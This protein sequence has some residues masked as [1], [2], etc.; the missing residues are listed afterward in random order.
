MVIGVMEI[1]LWLSEAHSLKDKRQVV[2]S[3]KDKIRDRFN[4]AV[5]EVADQDLWQKA[6]LAVCTVGSD[7]RVVNARLDQVVNFV[8]RLQVA[9]DLDFRLEMINL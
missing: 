6:L 8:E 3:V 9:T 2:K 7:G 5:A 1:R 4:V